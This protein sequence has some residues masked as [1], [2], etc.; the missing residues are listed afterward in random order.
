MTRDMQ[1]ILYLC[2]HESRKYIIIHARHAAAAAHDVA[3]HHHDG[4]QVVGHHHVVLHL[5]H[6]VVGMDAMRQLALHQ[7]SFMAVNSTRGASGL[8]SA[9]AR[10]PTTLPKGW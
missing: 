4:M 3:A 2:R 1:N 6:A 5:H 8:P 10:L 7:L 9:A